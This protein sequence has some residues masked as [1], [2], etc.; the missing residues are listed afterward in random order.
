MR[1]LGAQNVVRDTVQKDAFAMRFLDVEML[2]DISTM[3][4][5]A[6]RFQRV[7]EAD[8]SRAQH[9]ARLRLN[10]ACVANGD[11]VAAGAPN[12]GAIVVV[13]AVHPRKPADGDVF[14]EDVVRVRAVYLALFIELAHFALLRVGGCERSDTSPIEHDSARGLR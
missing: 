4:L 7:L 11:V 8:I 6:M 3:R 5:R 12:A 10:D 14:D 1:C 13:L 9:D 2:D